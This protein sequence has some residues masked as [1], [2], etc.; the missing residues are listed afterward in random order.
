MSTINPTNLAMEKKNKQKL[1]KFVS[2]IDN[3]E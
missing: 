3:Y 1:K 2:M